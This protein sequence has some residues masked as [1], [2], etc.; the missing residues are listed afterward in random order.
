MTFLLA[1]SSTALSSLQLYS[2]LLQLK[3]LD[4]GRCSVSPLTT[5]PRQGLNISIICQ[6]SSLLLSIIIAL[7]LGYLVLNIGKG[8][9]EIEKANEQ[10]GNALSR[11]A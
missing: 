4:E 10:G 6:A 3:L 5:Y 1:F 9:K 11:Q 8:K 7:I 2:G